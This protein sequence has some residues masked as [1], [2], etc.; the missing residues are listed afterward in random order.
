[1]QRQKRALLMTTDL[2]DECS[3]AAP[4]IH[5]GK[6]LSG[7]QVTHRQLNHFPQTA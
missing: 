2:K 4:V 1:M 6:K 3:G 5:T 7:V